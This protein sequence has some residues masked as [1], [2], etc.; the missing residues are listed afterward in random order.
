MTKNI[1]FS[2]ILFGLAFVACS[3]DDEEEVVVATIDNIEGEYVGSTTGTMVTIQSTGDE[4]ETAIVPNGDETATVTVAADG[5]ISLHQPTFSTAESS[6]PGA[7]LKGIAVVQD[8]DVLTFDV[9]DYSSMNGYY[10][11]AGDISGQF[12]GK[13]LKLDYTFLH[14][15]GMIGTVHFDGVRK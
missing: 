14:A 4:V 3:D 15:G 12:E 10:T 6:Y 9:K 11:V 13:T 5:T 8:G 1:L 7:F 2:A